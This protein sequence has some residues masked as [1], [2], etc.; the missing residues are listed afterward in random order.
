MNSRIAVAHQ[1]VLHSKRK[2]IQHKMKRKVGDDSPV[3]LQPTYLAADLCMPQSD[4]NCNAITDC[5]C[6]WTA[7]HEGLLLFEYYINQ[8][9]LHCACANI[10]YKEDKNIFLPVSHAQHTPA[11][12]ITMLLTPITLMRMRLI[13]ISMVSLGF[14]RVCL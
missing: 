12:E 7:E 4:C 2:H 8:T 10:L 6:G 3:L 5:C 11:K 14:T 9:W 1:C 13:A